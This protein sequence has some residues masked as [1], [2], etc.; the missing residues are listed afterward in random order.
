MVHGGSLDTRMKKRRKR[1]SLEVLEERGEV[2][3]GDFSA[4]LHSTRQ[5]RTVGNVGADV[6][7]GTCTA[8]CRPS[9]FIHI[10]P[11]EK[12]TLK[13]I[14]KALLFPAP[15]LPKGHKVMGYDDK[16]QC[17]M[18]VVDRCSIYAHRPQ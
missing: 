9:F 12:D 18:F 11:E 4:W 17:P 1:V 7:C 10:R 8:C 16:G 2:G 6:P 15:G 13:R 5:A 3:A 14:P